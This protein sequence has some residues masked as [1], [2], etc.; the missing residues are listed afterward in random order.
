MRPCVVV[1]TGMGGTKDSSLMPFAEAF[2]AEGLDALLFDYRGFGDSGGEPRQLAWPPRHRKDLRAAIEFAR[3][4]DGVDPD[5]I[6][7]W[8]WSWGA[9]HAIYAA[10]EDAAPIAALIALT[11]DADGLATIRH[12]GSQS[13]VAN[14]LR[15][16]ARAIRDL[17]GQARGRPAELV[18]MVG[19]PGSLAALATAD[20]EPGYKAVAGP[21]W[22]NE[23]V[24]RVALAEWVNRAVG[25][26]A[27]LRCPVLIQAGD[28]D[29]VAAPDTARKLAWE[30]KG[31]SELREYPGGHF[32]LLGDEHVIAH[33]LDFLRRHLAPAPE[34]SP[35][36]DPA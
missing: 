34:R 24:P 22:R 21:S 19:P 6:V 10:A 33:Q 5:R 11:P 16:N 8:G 2:A 25:K 4:L 17:V 30:A 27:D 7:L 20:S 26:T 3:G 31:R 23:V 1:A 12:L 18:P 13:S 28:A 32:D 36:P 15:L 9:S 14:V 29:T 35:A